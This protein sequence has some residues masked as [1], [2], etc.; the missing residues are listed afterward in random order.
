MGESVEKTLDIRDVH[1][2]WDASEDIRMR[3]RSG[4]GLLHEKSALCLDNYNAT[5][6]APV[7]RPLLMAM[8]GDAARKLPGVPDLRSELSAIFESSKRTGPEVAKFVATEPTRIR[9]LCSFVKAKCR[10]EEVSQDLR[11]HVRDSIFS[12]V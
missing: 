3:I 2:M 10:R 12:G 6:N 4:Y 7:L 11:M 8:G 5:L 1:K 9:K